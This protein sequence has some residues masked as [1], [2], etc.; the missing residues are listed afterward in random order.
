VTPEATTLL[1]QIE[2]ISA[3]LAILILLLLVTSGYL[4]QQQRRLQR[5]QLTLL[6]QLEQQQKDMRA[7]LQSSTQ[8]GERVGRLER[9][10][11]QL[12]SRQ[13]EQGLRGRDRGDEEYD[14]A[15]AQAIK[16]VR[17]GASVEE[18]VD[19]CGLARDE[20]ELIMRM[21][22]RQAAADRW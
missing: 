14:I 21:H 19:I 5:Q 18:L 3:I 13:E 1:T 2:P 22:R 8:V 10:T 12:A 6:T 9:A 20:A 17:K 7:L 16:L 11:K 15:Y 4:W